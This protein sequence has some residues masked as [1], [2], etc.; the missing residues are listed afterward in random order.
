LKNPNISILAKVQGFICV[1]C[2]LGENGVA[3]VV[4]GFICVL[5]NLGENGVARVVGTNLQ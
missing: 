3:R 1:L 5:S 2:N 4:Q